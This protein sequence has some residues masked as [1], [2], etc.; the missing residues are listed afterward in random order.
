MLL[1]KFW[2]GV[3][4]KLGEQLVVRLLTPAFFFWAGGL[5][6][7]T[8]NELGSDVGS[9]R[10]IAELERRT[11]TVRELPA[12]LQV[13]LV[14][15]ALSALVASALAAE[16]LTPALLRALEGYWPARV[17]GPLQ[18]RFSA[19]RKAILT[20][21]GALAHTRA[22]RALSPGEQAEMSWL[23][24]RARRLPTA[25]EL[26][27]PTRL[28]NVLRSAEARP[29]QQYGLDVAVCWPHLWLV[30][31][32]TSRQEVAAARGRLDAGART[33][34]W[35][36]LFAVWTVW[37]WWAAPIAVALSVATYYTSILSSAEVYGDLVE[38]TFALRRAELYRALRWPLP[39]S[40]A[41]ETGT[42]DALTM[43]LWRGLAPDGVVYSA[44]RD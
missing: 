1:T 21:L 34:L 27:L 5:L 13:A 10:W 12:A 18:R 36:V 14:V 37:A 39:A 8:W 17:S 28:G 22:Q 15:G 29:R 6:A 44:P 43:Y 9:R 42:G 41:E 16:R 26:M 3:G 7:W 32:E 38:A 31:D 4:G 23:E 11:E 2:E 19:R 35:A 24:G 25:A 40:P 30:L 33:W 20:R